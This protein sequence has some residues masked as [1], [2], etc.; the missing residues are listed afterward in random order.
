MVLPDR[1][2]DDQHAPLLARDP[3]RDDV[4][5]GVILQG[6]VHDRADGGDLHAVAE[7]AAGNR[8]PHRADLDHGDAPLLDFDEAVGVTLRPLEDLLRHHPELVLA[9]RRLADL[10]EFHV[11]DGALLAHRLDPL[12]EVHRDGV[13]VEELVDRQRD[14]IGYL[15]F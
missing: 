14:K 1:G 8:D 2:P 5:L 4:G 11:A 13:L 7:G 9:R 10:H 15:G 6:H 3:L 12:L